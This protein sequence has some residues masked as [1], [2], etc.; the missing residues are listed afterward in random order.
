[1]DQ[2][3]KFH[4]VTKSEKVNISHIKHSWMVMLLDIPLNS[5]QVGILGIL[6]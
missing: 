5:L 3:R 1:M 2:G 6:W 4:N